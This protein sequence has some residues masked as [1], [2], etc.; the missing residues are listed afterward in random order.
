M[1]FVSLTAARDDAKIEFS[2]YGS[3]FHALAAQADDG[4]DVG[5]D[6]TTTQ[7]VLHLDSDLDGADNHDCLSLT[8]LKTASFV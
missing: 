1:G 7:T 3:T 5:A 2:S 6:L 8:I 4:I